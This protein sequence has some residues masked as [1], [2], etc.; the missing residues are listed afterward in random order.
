MDKAELKQFFKKDFPR[1]YSELGELVL[2][3]FGQAEPANRLLFVA[4]DHGDEV[5]GTQSLVK[6][7][8]ELANSSFIGIGVDIVPVV[9]VEGYPTVRTVVGYSGVGQQKALDAS[10]FDESPLPVIKDLRNILT[11]KKY[12]IVCMLNSRFK[13]NTPLLDGFFVEPQISV[14]DGKLCFVHQETSDLAGFIAKSL[15][16][17]GCPVLNRHLNGYL[18]GGYSFFSQGLVISG[19]EENG[20]VAWETMLGFNKYC[21][22]NG[23]P[24]LALTSISSKVDEELQKESMKSHGIA[25]DAVIRFYSSLK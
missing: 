19:R 13:E 3:E 9:D 4:S 10:Y 14:A 20:K 1:N 25:V 23:I 22:Q 7:A 12:D 16:D 15:N 17:T 18:G 11:T 8:L 5:S 21:Q 24:S 6:K 2:L